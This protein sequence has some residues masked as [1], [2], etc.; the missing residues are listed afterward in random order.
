MVLSKLFFQLSRIYT[1]VKDMADQLDQYM[2]P[3]APDYFDELANAMERRLYDH[4]IRREMAANRM[5]KDNSLTEQTVD[6]TGVDYVFTDKVAL[7]GDTKPTL[8]DMER[9]RI[10]DFT[11]YTIDDTYV[12]TFWRTLCRDRPKSLGGLVKGILGKERTRLSCSQ[13]RHKLENRDN[14]W[15]AYDQNLVDN[16]EGGIDWKFGSIRSFVL[17]KSLVNDSR[18][19]L[20]LVDMLTDVKEFEFGGTV[21][22]YT[23]RVNGH[24]K[25][26]TRLVI[27]DTEHIVEQVG[28]VQSGDKSFIVGKDWICWR[29]SDYDSFEYGASADDSTPHP[30]NSHARS[31]S[32]TRSHGQSRAQSHGQSRARSH[33]QSQSQSHDQ[34][35][36]LSRA[37]SHARSQT[38][39]QAQMGANGHN[40]GNTSGASSGACTDGHSRAAEDNYKPAYWSSDDEY[41]E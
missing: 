5:L 40:V 28:L 30:E 38:R 18:R 8:T 17:V 29:G 3:G 24:T 19:F 7:D 4:R 39:S 9:R 21:F 32:Q 41:F 27:I 15:I 34:S 13:Y 22:I 33:A 23:R 12:V 37:R 26:R 16:K 2:D 25:R 31:Q 36:N 6:Q 1:G 10:E 14:F 11:G 35:Q 20:I